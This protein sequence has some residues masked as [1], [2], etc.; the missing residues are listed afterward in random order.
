MREVW[1]GLFNLTVESCCVTQK[2]YL[3][4]DKTTENKKYIPSDGYPADVRIPRKIR[5]VVHVR[6]I[7]NIAKLTYM[8]ASV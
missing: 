7:T 8:H 6:Y 4:R 5:L 3:I 1:F 2:T